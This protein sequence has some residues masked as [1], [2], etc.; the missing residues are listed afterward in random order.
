MSVSASCNHC[1]K[2]VDPSRDEPCPHCGRYAGKT[3]QANI[4]DRVGIIDRVQAAVLQT[5]IREFLQ[6]NRGWVLCLAAIILFSP[7]VGELIAGPWGIVVGL[8]L[9]VLSVPV[10]ILAVTKVRE[11]REKESEIRE[12]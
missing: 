5:H 12:K 3:I 6:Y 11:I 8:L 2:P 9:S 4:A 7:F 1:G 10:G